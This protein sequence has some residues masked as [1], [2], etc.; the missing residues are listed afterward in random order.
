MAQAAAAVTVFRR[1]R[2][3]YRAYG[4]EGVGFDEGA[5]SAHRTGLRFPGR[6]GEFSI[7]QQGQSHLHP[8]TFASSS[9]VECLLLVCKVASA[10]APY[11][12]C[13]CRFGVGNWSCARVHGHGVGVGSRGCVSSRIRLGHELAGGAPANN[14]RDLGHGRLP[15]EVA[16]KRGGGPAP[17]R[18]N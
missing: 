7:A 1:A 6:H 3:A 8:C 15:P 13:A 17:T 4:E 18:V 9:M 2:L 5:H 12:R 16:L 10:H 11:I 14:A